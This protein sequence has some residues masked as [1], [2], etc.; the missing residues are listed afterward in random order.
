MGGRRSPKPKLLSILTDHTNPIFSVAFNPDR[1]TLATGS[2][3]RTA[4]LWDTDVNSA[5]DRICRTA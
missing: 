1:H 5:T 2:S 3:D 4:R